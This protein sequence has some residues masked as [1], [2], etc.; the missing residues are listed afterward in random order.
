VTLAY[1]GFAARFPEFKQVK[2]ETVEAKIA[3]A[4]LQVA[5][6]VYGA[7]TDLAVGYLAAH[8]LSIAPT[9]QQAR[10]VPKNAKANREDALTTY[11]REYRR[12]Q[13]MVTSGFRVTGT[14]QSGNAGEPPI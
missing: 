6:A 5:E 11:E 7:K 14:D 13:R 1:D 4:I 3:E 8:L 10:L 12:I 2:R 9:G